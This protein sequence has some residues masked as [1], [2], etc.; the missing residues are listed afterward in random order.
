MVLRVRSIEGG[1]DQNGTARSKSKDSIGKEKCWFSGKSGHLRKDCWKR[2]QTSK[3]DSTKEENSTI[4]MVDEVF[5]IC[6]VSSP[7]F[8]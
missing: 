2:Q 3:D 4:G 7:V 6:C 8:A 5:S 1:K